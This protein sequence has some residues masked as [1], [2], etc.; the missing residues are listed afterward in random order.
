MRDKEIVIRLKIPATPRTRWLLTIGGAVLVAGAAAY[1]ADV[2]T[3][4]SG[5][6]L[7]ADTMNTNF[8]SL[9]DR[10]AALESH[11]CGATQDMY[12][13]GEVGG[14]YM[15][16]ARCLAVPGCATYQT[17][18]MC[19]AE[20]VVRTLAHGGTLPAGWFSAGVAAPGIGGGTLSDCGGW[21]SDRTDLQGPE[22]AGPAV[23]VDPCNNSHK[24]LCCAQQ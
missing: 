12:N 11:Y 6:R 23:S 7:S 13:G 10:I 18:H 24:L 20:D 1:A 16:S 3:F 19:T 22:Y 8:K 4:N 21:T 14:Y 2:T 5:D 15:A 9:Q 17:A